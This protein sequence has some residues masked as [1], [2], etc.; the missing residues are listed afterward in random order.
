MSNL[1][2]ISLL[3][4][5]LIAGERFPMAAGNVLYL[6]PQTDDT[7]YL[8]VGNGT[9]SMDLKWVGDTSAKYV[10]MD[11]GNSRLQLEDIDMVLGDNDSIALGDGSDQVLKWNGS[12]LECGPATGMWAGAPSPADP[13]YIAV[14]HEFTD[15]FNGPALD[16]ASGKWLEVDDAGTGTNA[17]A[18][19]AGGVCN[20]VTAAADNDYHAITSI[21]E[22]FLFLVGKK[23]WFEAR[24]KLTEAN[25]NESAWWF[26][27][28]DTL[29]TGGIQADDSGP[30][31]SYDGALIWKDE[32]TMTIDFETSNAATQATAAADGGTFVSGT[33]TTVGFYFDGTAT[34]STI[35][36]YYNVAGGSTLTAGTAK[37]ITL[38]GLEEMHL[39]AGVKAGP[40][41]GAET[42]QIDYIKCVQLR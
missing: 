23:L 22:S 18:D 15:D 19:V 25:V 12:Y 11:V 6:L 34:T 20:I 26:G 5:A 32:G 10:L 13:R 42:L 37:D 39:V 2:T 27:L 16:D 1:Q 21:G 3:N 36:P 28:T 4:S 30:L 38:A 35:T 40:S 33:W 24:F 14:A 41:G 17:L 31:A 9:Y 7:G 8:Q 29:T